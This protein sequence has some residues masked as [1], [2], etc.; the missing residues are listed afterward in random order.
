[1]LRC[2][3]AATSRT[4]AARL[5]FPCA[6]ALLI[7]GCA[8]VPA[9]R[10]AGR[11]LVVEN[12]SNHPARLYYLQHGTGRWLPLVR[13][14]IYME[15][16]QRVRVPMAALGSAGWIRIAVRFTDGLMMEHGRQEPAAT[17]AVSA[18]T[19]VE[20]VIRYPA[21]SSGPSGR[22]WQVCD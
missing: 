9:S 11:Y 13:R 22:E 19:M 14:D 6:L 21:V 10:A 5:V 18:C 15:Q 3:R 12:R 4:R 8:S 16:P 7:V 2:G 17:F 1:M 20:V